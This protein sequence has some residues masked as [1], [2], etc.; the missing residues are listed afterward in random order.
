MEEDDDDDF[1]HDIPS[2]HGILKLKD[3][4]STTSE[5]SKT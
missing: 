2:Q 3:R 4:K 1:N 5:T